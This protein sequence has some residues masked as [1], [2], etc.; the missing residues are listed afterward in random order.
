[1]TGPRKQTSYAGRD[2][3]NG[4]YVTT[5]MEDTGSPDVTIFADSQ[6]AWAPASKD[7]TIE[8]LDLRYDQAVVPT[9]VSIHET[10]G[11]GSVTKVEAYDTQQATWTTLWQG[12]DTTPADAIGIF[13]PSLTGNDVAADRIRITVDTNVPDWNEIDAVELVGT[14]PG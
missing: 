1:M 12:T 13:T 9:A 3:I 6:Q 14:P 4:N 11:P 2:W 10:A 5:A 8:W 7:G